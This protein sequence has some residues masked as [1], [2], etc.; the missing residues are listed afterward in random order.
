MSAMDTFSWAMGLVREKP[1]VFVPALGLMALD[2]LT[3]ATLGVW[4]IR[5][6][7]LGQISIPLL[8]LGVLV[9]LVASSWASVSTAVL[10]MRSQKEDPLD[11][12]EAL[13]HGLQRTP[14]AVLLGL[15]FLVLLFVAV[16][17]PGLFV[18][19]VF[20]PVPSLL[21]L[22]YIVLAVWFMV[23][24]ARLALA[25]AGVADGL[26]PSEAISESWNLSRGAFLSLL[27][28]L[29]LCV[30]VEV[31]LELLALIPLVGIIVGVFATGYT[32]YLT[33]AAFA[34]A[35]LALQEAQAEEFP[36]DV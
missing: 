15:E 21:I 26:A 28:L 19:F 20:A 10:V 1:A 5:D 23:L 14:H 24:G 4:T 9:W 29:I 33:S 13:R 34:L 32:I 3:R 18:T 17:L 12:R 27:G 2:L 30:L 7:D 8:V 6:V 16:G 36:S 35:Y 25:G 11:W 31:V 22:A